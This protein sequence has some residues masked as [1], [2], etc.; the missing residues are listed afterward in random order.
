M[1]TKAPSTHQKAQKLQ[2]KI[3]QSLKQEVALLLGEP[4]ESIQRYERQARVDFARLSPRLK[5]IA[6]TE[7]V[8]AIQNAEVTFIADF[9]TFDQAQKT[10]LRLIRSAVR[11]QENWVIGLELVP[12]QYQ[13]ELNRYQRGQL[14]TTEFLKAISYDQQW[15]FPWKNYAPIFQW[16]RENQV[17]LIALNRPERLLRPSEE[18]DLHNRDQWAAGVITDLFFQAKKRKEPLKMIV[19][20]GE[21]HVSSPHLPAELKVISKSFLKRSLSHV[22]IH[23]N[24]DQLFWKATRQEMDVQSQAVVLKK[25]IFCVLSST[26]WAKLQSLINW[27]EAGPEEDQEMESNSRTTPHSLNDTEAD[28]LL[29]LHSGA[30][31]D[32]LHQMSLYGS[33]IAEFLGVSPPSFESLNIY[34]IENF[35]FLERVKKEGLFNRAELSLIRYHVNQNRPL[36]LPRLSAAYLGSCSHNTLADLSAHHIL[37]CHSRSELFYSHQL[38]DFYRL[39]LE[40]CFGFFGSLILNPH[41]KCDLLDDHQK[42]L[43]A[44]SEGSPPNFPFEQ[45]ARQTTRLCLLNSFQIPEEVRSALKA[46]KQEVALL[47]ACRY[48]GQILGKKLHRA[49]LQ[50]D[51]PAGLI[52]STFLTRI[53][54]EPGFFQQRFE[55]LCAVTSR[56]SLGRTKNETL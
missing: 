50:G 44:L 38:E 53:T 4:P 18:Q 27:A 14:S 34:T 41:R 22:I 24:D 31:D 45:E 39:C 16:A 52:S 56:I 9:H 43:K 42:R 55:A 12:S 23:Q 30:L 47:L 10:A 49:T 20:Y 1:N 5:S 3:L 21:L 36:Y 25:N 29:R 33:T 19:L 13:N 28:P 17:P 51:L 15:G 37:R 32:Y 26:P 46:K 2:R 8:Q 6:K 11:A 35:N 7:L 54:S 48:L 40:A